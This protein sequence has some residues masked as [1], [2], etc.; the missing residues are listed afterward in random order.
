MNSW[1][2]V[3][4]GSASVKMALI[5]EEENLINSCYHRNKGLIET[6]KQGLEEF[7]DKGYDICGVGGTGSGREFTKILIGGDLIKSEVLAHV[8]GTLKY[9]PDTQVVSDIGGEDSKLMIVRDGILEDFILNNSCSSGTGSSLESIAI[10]LGIPIEEV[11]E[12]ALQSK[13]NLNI[14]TKCGVFMTSAAINH[15]NNGAKKED[16]LMG[17]VRGMV[18]NYLT[19]AQ[20]KDLKSQHIYTGMT[21]R[22]PAIVKAFNEQLEHEVEV[23]EYAPIMGAIGMALIVKREGVYESDFKGFDVKDINYKVKTITSNRCENA[24]EI[25]YLSNE[26]GLLGCLG[27]RCDDCSIRPSSMRKK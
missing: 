24:C 27:N 9:Y 14:S 3:D 19:M 25:S 26:H 20:G 21:A 18:A 5:D 12:Y 11:G 8:V 23:P 4:C 16:I 2:G 7:S 1:L 6:I 13:K 17:V 10:R 22:N 15:L